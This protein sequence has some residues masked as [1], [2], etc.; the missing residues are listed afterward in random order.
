[1]PQNVLF[2]SL[3]LKEHT[4]VWCVC[5]CVCVYACVRKCDVHIYASL[6]LGLCVQTTRLPSNSEVASQVYF[7]NSSKPL[8]SIA[9]I[10]IYHQA[11]RSWH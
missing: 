9:T 6:C 2:K 8:Q 3:A 4:A 5:V 1:M 10:R 7:I 11:K